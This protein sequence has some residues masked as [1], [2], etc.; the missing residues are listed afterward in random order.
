M[1]SQFYKVSSTMK[2]NLN[3]KSG[4]GLSLIEVVVGVTIIF[5]TLTGLISAYNL[6][7]EAALQNT[8]K[9]QAAYLVEEGLEAIRQIRD[10]DW[11]TNI[12]SLNA[13]VSY[14][15]DFNGSKWTST[16]S[17]SLI[18][19]VFFRE[20]GFEDVYRDVNDDISVAGD[21]DP[22]T[23]FFT[24]TISWSEKGATTTKSISAYMSKIF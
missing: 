20:F 2:R 14:G 10:E 21:L 7:L 16:T 23:K 1:A 12:A 6:F 9:V 24:V 5:I 3:I 19:G 18:D 17:Q 8:K 15:F 11:D 13:G 4:A 22:D